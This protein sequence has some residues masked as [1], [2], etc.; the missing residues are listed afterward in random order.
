M[1]GTALL[2]AVLVVVALVAKDKALGLWHDYRTRR[3]PPPPDK[4]PLI[5]DAVIEACAE[6]GLNRE[7]L[8]EDTE[9][10]VAG[11]V[12][13]VLQIAGRKL[14]KDVE[15]RTVGDVIDWLAEAPDRA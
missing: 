12:N 3:L 1:V 6:V 2:T 9:L 5:I 4:S 10:L 7:A 14:G 13:D 15:L 11:R 8:R